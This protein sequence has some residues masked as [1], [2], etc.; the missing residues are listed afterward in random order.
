MQCDRVWSSGACAQGVVLGVCF[1]KPAFCVDLVSPGQGIARAL[2]G[3][4]QVYVSVAGLDLGVGMKV[5]NAVLDVEGSLEL[6]G[7]IV[8]AHVRTV[9]IE[10]EDPWDL[11]RFSN[12]RD[13]WP[14]LWKDADNWSSVVLS[15]AFACFAHDLMRNAEMILRG[16]LPRMDP[17]KI[18]FTPKDEN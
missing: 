18:V 6:A 13:P 14:A 3:T 9:L 2:V 7:G 15:V 5:L 11:V 4:G 16:D 17:E 1:L 12:L 8:D 10:A